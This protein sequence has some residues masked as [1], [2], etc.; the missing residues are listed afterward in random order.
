MVCE[1]N[2]SDTLHGIAMKLD[3]LNCHGVKMCISFFYDDRQIFPIVMALYDLENSLQYRYMVCERNFSDTLHG[4][5]MK[6]NTLNCH[7]VEMCI[8]F[9]L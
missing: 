7:D 3:T 4:I 2:F 8:S 9:F 6:L 5:G 1:R